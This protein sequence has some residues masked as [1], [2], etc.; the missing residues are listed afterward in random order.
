MTTLIDIHLTKESAQK[1]GVS[2]VYER[3][4]LLPEANEHVE[5]FAK[6]DEKAGKEWSDAINSYFGKKR[7]NA[8]EAMLTRLTIPFHEVGQVEAEAY[9]T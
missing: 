8:K 7:S 2:V 4:A 5:H 9:C 6:G 3:T 1:T